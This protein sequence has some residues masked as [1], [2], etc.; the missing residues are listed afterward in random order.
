ML[1]RVTKELTGLAKRLGIELEEMQEKYAEIATSNGLD[2]DDERQQLTALVL[3][4]NF[5]R[6]RLAGAR[7]TGGYG[8][9]GVGY[10]VAVE[11]VRDV[12]EW[13]RR[14]VLSRFRSDSQQALKDG[15]L[16]EVVVNDDG[17]Y[18]A[19]RYYNDEWE[20]KVVGQ[21][22]ASAMEVGENNWIVPL[23]AV[24]T[25]ASGDANK[26]YGKPLPQEE[27]RVRAHFIG[28]KVGE[29]TQMWTVQLKGDDAKNFNVQT[30]RPV[31]LY[32]MFNEDRNAIYGIKG[33]TRAS[34]QY[35]DLLDEDDERYFDVATVDFEEG[36]AEHCAEYLADLIEL[37]TYHESIMQTQGPRLI[38]TDGIVTSMNLTPN[39]KTGNRVMWVEPVDANY[40]F[41]D[42]DIPESTPIWVPSH[43]DINFGVGSDVIVVG[44]TNQTQKKDDDGMP[45]DGEYNPVTINLYGVYARN[46]TG[47]PEEMAQLVE[48]EDLDF[49]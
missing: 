31:S 1:E 38:V 12:M 30:F 19:T 15:L 49:F 11:A 6:G 23:D 25:W 37:D 46:A 33:K 43:I 27:W 45:I 4:R 29:E 13:K 44:R 32:G 18:E 7:N 28:N 26:N 21:V 24:K 20:T 39:E 47:A 16:A 35:I 17:A 14:N 8:S 10:F 36:I 41:S 3:T 2:T 5:A 22:P 48:A 42:E 34:I 9:T 40:G